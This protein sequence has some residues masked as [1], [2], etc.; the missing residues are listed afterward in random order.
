MEDGSGTSQHAGEV[1]GL[2]GIRGLFQQ[3][4]PGDSALLRLTRLR[5]AQAGMPAE[6]YADHPDELDR[7]LALV[8][9]HPTLP[10][11]HLNRRLD[12]LEESARVAVA[13]F[14][15]RFEGRVAGFVVHDKPQQVGRED[16]L[17]DGLREIAD[18]TSGPLVF[19]EYAAGTP[20]DWFAGVAH[21]V[22]EV[23]R[24]S[25]CVD[26][27]HVGLA[28]VRRRLAAGPGGH[29]ATFSLTDPVLVRHADR[30]QRATRAALPAVLGLIAELAPLGKTLHF[31]LHDGHPAVTGLSDHFSFLTRFPVP[32]R[33]EGVQSLAPMF[34]PA[35]LAE[36]LGEALARCTPQ[37]LSL[38][39]EVHQAEG[40]LPL[41]R[42]T[43]DLFRHW[44]DLTNA[45]RQNHWLQVVADNQLLARTQ[46]EAAHAATG[47][48]AGGPVIPP[49]RGAPP[50]DP[51]PVV[52]DPSLS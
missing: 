52:T 17:V 44:L 28:E 18:R 4:V 6:L 36:I 5:F 9:E 27:G 12:L 37:R 19:L 10:T 49:G 23:E 31:H 21:R 26:I 47:S 42:D 16:R 24:A 45:E 32:F 41:G 29:G 34:G 38:T 33:Y 25:V 20:L 40:R 15:R 51:R 48:R 7:L 22:A 3:R 30:V 35:G 46:L 39:M 2:P 43:R 8:P 50:P 14:I 13:T 1:S 11:V